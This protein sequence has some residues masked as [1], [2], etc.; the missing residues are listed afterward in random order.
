MGGR[1]GKLLFNGHRVFVGDNENVLGIDD[2][3]KTLR[4]YLMPLNQAFM[5]GQND[6]YYIC[7]F[8][9]DKGNLSYKQFFSDSHFNLWLNHVYIKASLRT[10][11][12]S[13]QWYYELTDVPHQTI[14]CLGTELY[15]ALYMIDKHVFS[16]CC[17]LLWYML[18][19]KK[20]NNKTQYLSSRSL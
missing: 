20:K 15:T 17:I 2:C 14:N 4:M 16:T 3:Y 12:H 8:Y 11:I 6:K 5:N 7:I 19:V 9:H 10:L 1:N 18:E 13:A